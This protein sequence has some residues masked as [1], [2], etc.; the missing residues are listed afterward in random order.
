[1]KGA[2]DHPCLSCNVMDATVKAG[3]LRRKNIR[4][5]FCGFT[6]EKLMYRNFGIL[7][8]YNGSVSRETEVGTENSIFREQVSRED[9]VLCSSVM[10][11]VE[12]I[13][14]LNIRFVSWPQG[15]KVSSGFRFLRE[16]S[17]DLSFGIDEPS[18]IVIGTFS[19]PCMGFPVVMILMLSSLGDKVPGGR[20]RNDGRVDISRRHRTMLALASKGTNIWPKNS[21]LRGSERNSPVM[22]SASASRRIGVFP[23]RD[24]QVSIKTLMRGRF[25]ELASWGAKMTLFQRVSVEKTRAFHSEQTRERISRMSHGAGGRMAEEQSASVKILA[26]T[27]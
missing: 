23:L 13:G 7:T 26:R 24:S 2:N 5:S 11:V 27:L 14:S 19:A 25:R 22:G 20:F 10:H 1:M 6:S 12:E 8:L 17:T 16:N 21:G 3:S 18:K 4:G 9:E 15:R